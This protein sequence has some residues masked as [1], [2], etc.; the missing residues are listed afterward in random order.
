MKILFSLLCSLQIS[1]AAPILIDDVVLENAFS[2]SVGALTENEN[3]RSGEHFAKAVNDCPAHCEAPQKVTAAPEDPTNSVF[4]IGAVYKCDKCDKWHIAGIATAWCLSADGLMVTNHHVLEKA[5]GTVMGICNRKGKAWPITEVIAADPAQDIAIFRVEGKDFSPL[6]LAK[7]A[8]IGTRVR[9]ISHPDRMFYTQTFG[10]VARYHVGSRKKKKN[11]NMMITADYA[12][13]SSGG[14][15]LNP[16]NEVIGMVS[17][18]KPVYYSTKKGKPTG[19]LQ[20][21]V[22]N[23]VPVSAIHKMFKEK[24]TKAN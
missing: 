7:P 16:D 14:P 21:V 15:V 6:P 8:D 23:C 5:K 13:G 20:M 2:T 12:K 10:E 3:H 24:A 9:V 11:I 4:L 19:P 18:T 1:T 22:K 17:S